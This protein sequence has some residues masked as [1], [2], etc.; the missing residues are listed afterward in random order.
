MAIAILDLFSVAGRCVLRIKDTI[1]RI[2]MA[3]VAYIRVRLLTD[4]NS[5]DIKY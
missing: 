5:K 1:E 3:K 2:A 4:V